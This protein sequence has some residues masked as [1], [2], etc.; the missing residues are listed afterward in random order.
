VKKK[1]KSKKKKTKE[2]PTKYE[3]S[4]CFPTTKKGRGLS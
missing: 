4:F 1:R 3:T 2:E